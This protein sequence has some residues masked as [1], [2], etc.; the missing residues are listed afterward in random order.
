[1]NY[2][3]IILFI[4]LFSSRAYCSDTR[5]SVFVSIPPQE[6]FVERIAGSLVNVHVLNAKAQDP[7]T[8]SPTPKQLVELSKANLFF[9]IGLPFERRL[10]GKIRKINKSLKIVPTDKNIRKQLVNGRA[11]QNNAGEPD[12]HI[13]LS[14]P[15]IKIQ[16]MNIEEAL[17]IADP[18]H[19]QQYKKNLAVFLEDIDKLDIEIKKMLAPY[20]GETFYV[21][22][23]AFGWF[24][25]RYGLEQQ[26]VEIE[27]KLPTAKQLS[28]LIKS[29][30]AENIRL[31][32]VQPQFDRRC[33][34]TLAQAI[35]C[36]VVPINPLEKNVVLNLKDIALKIE[37][38]LKKPHGDNS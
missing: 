34:E 33:A 4:A 6:Y 28:R 31:I 29:A 5:L 25:N 21:F 22:H 2:F 17:T 10:I 9:T 30:R 14:P 35:G 3:Y 37:R 1:M 16:A 13:W 23:P 15:L 11:K 38:A 32:F 19:A 20:K 36:K 26:A 7:H 12:L 27:G 8:F 18:V 24:A